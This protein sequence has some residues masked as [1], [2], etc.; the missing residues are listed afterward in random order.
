VLWTVGQGRQG[1]I[2]INVCFPLFYGIVG[3]PTPSIQI[4]VEKGEKHINMKNRVSSLS[5]CPVNKRQGIK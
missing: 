4:L 2:K 3:K 1:I 5:A